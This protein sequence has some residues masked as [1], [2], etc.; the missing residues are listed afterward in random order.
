MAGAGATL[1]MLAILAP[2]AAADFAPDT[3]VSSDVITQPTPQAFSVCHA[4]A[5]ALVTQARLE[6][7]QWR[8]ITEVFDPPA[9][10]ASEER[11]RVAAAIARF[12]LLVG[13]MTDTAGDR[14]E[15]ETGQS[16]W[17]Q[18]DCIDE[19][20]NT[21]TYLRML[22]TAGVLTWHRVEARVTRG[23]FLFGWPHTT[24]VISEIAGGAKWAVDS[25][26]HENGK[27]PEIV[28]IAL[29]KSGW[30]PGAGRAVASKP[31]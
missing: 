19:S 20:T 1:A 12:E 30:R 29:W 31:R 26:F 4:G 11:A 3:F 5:C 16:W 2:A 13:E 22:A 23:F 6:P 14:P 8:Q 25:W 10:D 9:R 15:N 28:P 24:A 27:P 7:A 21:T 17:S 18:M